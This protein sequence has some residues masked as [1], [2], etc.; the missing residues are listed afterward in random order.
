MVGLGLLQRLYVPCTCIFICFKS[1]GVDK[2]PFL[3]LGGRRVDHN[4]GH[5]SLLS[6]TCDGH[7]QDSMSFDLHKTCRLFK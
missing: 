2:D 4:E 1:E 6:S 3:L 7:P 5:A